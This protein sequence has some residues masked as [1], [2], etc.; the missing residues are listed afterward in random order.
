MSTPLRVAIVGCG[1]IADEHMK[2]WRNVGAKVV[3]LCDKDVTLAK[4]KAEKWGV[5]RY[6]EDV[7]HMIDSEKN[8]CS[9]NLYAA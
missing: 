6:Y 1:Q 9:I 8:R 2:A 5:Q 3:A 7:S 4:T